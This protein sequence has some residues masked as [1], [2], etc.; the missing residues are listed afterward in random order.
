MST[1]FTSENFQNCNFYDILVVLIICVRSLLYENSQWHVCMYPHRC[2]WV[3]LM[4][5]RLPPGVSEREGVVQVPVPQGLLR[6]GQ[7]GPGV[8]GCQW[9]LFPPVTAFLAVSNSPHPYLL[10][11]PH[12]TCMLG[13]ACKK[14][15]F[16]VPLFCH[17]YDLHGCLGIKQNSHLCSFLFAAD[18][19]CMAGWTLRKTAIFAPSSL[20]LS[21]PAWLAGH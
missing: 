14:Q 18:T 5:Q 11:A 13:W 1:M 4:G 8:Q 2:G 7:Q 10:L 9:V 19:T 3:C 20:P 12:M 17:W 21:R 6:H 16:S 15:P